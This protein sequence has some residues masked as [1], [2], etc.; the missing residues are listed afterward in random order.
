M[1]GS[2]QREIQGKTKY[3]RSKLNKRK[4][5]KEIQGKK[6]VRRDTVK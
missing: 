1:R 5:R 6:R 4:K 3:E 2:R